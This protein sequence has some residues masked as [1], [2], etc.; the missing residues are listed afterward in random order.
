MARLGRCAITLG[1]RFSGIADRAP[2]DLE[3]DHVIPMASRVVECE[4]LTLDGS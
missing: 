2:N 3:P 4:S 1:R